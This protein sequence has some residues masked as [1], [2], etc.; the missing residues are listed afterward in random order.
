MSRTPRIMA[1]VNYAASPFIHEMYVFA[2][3][4]YVCSIMLCLSIPKIPTVLNE[5]NFSLFTP[6][7]TAETSSCSSA[8]LQSLLWLNWWGHWIRRRSRRWRQLQRE[9]TRTR[10]RGRNERKTPPRWYT[11]NV[12]VGREEIKL[13]TMSTTQH[14]ETLSLSPASYH[15]HQASAVILPPPSCILF[16]P[17]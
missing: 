5:S 2:S 11:P 8:G 6:Q 16:R 13:T 3:A 9:S 1:G 10:E 12:V 4:Y 14:V 15:S 7:G 17:Q